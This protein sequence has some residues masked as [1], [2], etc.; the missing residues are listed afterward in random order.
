[1]DFRRYANVEANLFPEMRHRLEVDRTIDPLDLWAVLAWKANRKKERHLE[2]F[3]ALGLTFTEATKKISIGLSGAKDDRSRL[4]MLM[5]EMGFRLPT[6]TAILSVFYPDRF[7]IY[8]QR[9]CGVLADFKRLSYLKHDHHQLWP[10]YE[11]YMSAVKAAAPS[12]ASL[13]E[14]D[15]Y[16]WGKSWYLQAKEKIGIE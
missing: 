13:R 4:A 2:R 10:E 6:A 5:D 15:H 9:V 11:K 16:L 14:A 3:K 1:M 7:T 12:C 8:D